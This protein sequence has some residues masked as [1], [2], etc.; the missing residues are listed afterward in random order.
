MGNENP[1]RVQAGAS[2]GMVAP[3][4]EKGNARKRVVRKTKLGSDVVRTWCPKMLAGSGSL[5][6]SIYCLSSDSHL[7]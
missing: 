1:P 7:D 2:G 5:L 4:M 3:C 6:R